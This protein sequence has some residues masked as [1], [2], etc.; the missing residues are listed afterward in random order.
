M[1]F[2]HP[3]GLAVVTSPRG[4]IGAAIAPLTPFTS[5]WFLVHPLALFEDS[6]TAFANGAQAAGLAAVFGTAIAAVGYTFVILS[7]YSGLV[8]NFDMIVRKQSGT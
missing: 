2:S 6:A 4:E 5:I 7:I 1:A 3:I 8:R